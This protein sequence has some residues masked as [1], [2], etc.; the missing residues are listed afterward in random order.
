VRFLFDENLDVRFGR[1]LADLGHDVEFVAR[2]ARSAIDR[3]VLD[4]AVREERVLVTA[5]RDFGELVYARGRPHSGV[6]YLRLGRAP[7][8]Q[9]IERLAAAEDV[10]AARPATFAT[11]TMQT[12]RFARS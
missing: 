9:R 11:V 10:I 7:L 3:E 8:R 12:I 6:L 2:I 5:D 1:A 4:L